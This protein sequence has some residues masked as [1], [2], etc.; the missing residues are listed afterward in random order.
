MRIARVRTADGPRP[1]VLDDGRWHLVDDPWADRP[2]R[3]GASVAADEAELLAPCAPQVVVGMAH[4]H[5]PQDR[6]LPPQAFLKSARTVV[7]PGQATEVDPAGGPVNAEAELAVVIG[8]TARRLRPADVEQVIAGWTVADDVTRVGQVRHDSLFTQVKNG[9]GYTP[10]G[11]W[12]CTDL[13]PVLDGQPVALRTEVLDLDGTERVAE[14]STADLAWT[15]REQLVYLTAH[16]TLGPGDVVLTGAPG[17]SLPVRPGSRVRVH[18]DGVGTLH[19]PAH[20]VEAPADRS[21][22]AAARA[23]AAT[24]PHAGPA[25]GSPG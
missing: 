22:R 12:V 23:S 20:A 2:H 25:V 24:P 4:N 10:L 14:G 18:V 5:G 15:V 3:T 13:G 17:T 19:H 8:R 21:A 6:L 9:D 1:A 16:L 7:G 11:P